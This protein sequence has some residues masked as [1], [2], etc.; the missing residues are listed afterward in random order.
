MPKALIAQDLEK[1]THLMKQI[2]HTSCFKD[3]ARMGGLTNHTYHV[4]LENGNEYVIRIPG[5][6]TEELIIRSN[7]KVSTELACRLG[8]DANMLY[9]GDDGSKVT[10]YIP[11]AVTMSA[12]LLAQERHIEQVAQILKTMHTCGEDTGVPFEVFDMAADY[13]K[14]IADLNVPMFD[15]Y[16]AKKQEVIGI[17]AKVDAA[18]D[19]QKVPCHN[20]PLCENWVE[21]DG[22]M[23]LID[24]E[25][26]GMNDGMW[27][28]A[29]VSIEAGFDEAQDN[30]LLTRYLGKAPGITDRMHFLASKIYVD[31]LWT[32]WAKARVPYDGQPMEDWAVERYA[33]MKENIHAFRKIE[34]V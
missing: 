18:V 9:F 11:N 1:I 20:D 33:R 27:D 26:A 5:E 8:V 25:Y 12:G 24:W 28:V 22:R 10:A 30:L 31:Y 7:E 17:K 6:G 2:L 16:P 34:G 21:G 4:T 32:L 14:I 13:E 15:D 23:Y 3:I 19:I 29:D